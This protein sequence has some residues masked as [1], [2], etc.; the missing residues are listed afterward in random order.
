MSKF[1]TTPEQRSL[2]HT[3]TLTP[4][5]RSFLAEKETLL[6]QHKKWNPTYT[7]RTDKKMAE[8]GMSTEDIADALQKHAPD[9]QKLPC[10]GIRQKAAEKIAASAANGRC[11]EQAQ[12]KSAASR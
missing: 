10:A 12:K 6:A 11:A 3:T 9:I 7:V 2:T 1:I 8:Q 5:E 4:A